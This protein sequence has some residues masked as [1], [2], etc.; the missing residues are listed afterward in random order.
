MVVLLPIA[1]CDIRDIA[2]LL[3]AC[4]TLDVLNAAESATS[5]LRLSS[6]HKERYEKLFAEGAWAWRCCVLQASLDPSKRLGSATLHSA[7]YR[8][9][10]TVHG[11]LDA[12]RASRCLHHEIRRFANLRFVIG[13]QPER[14]QN[15]VERLAFG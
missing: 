8:R 7:L 6:E 15:R 10:R 3:G 11:D 12:N 9:A 2:H 5:T 1:P 13:V 14:A 4:R